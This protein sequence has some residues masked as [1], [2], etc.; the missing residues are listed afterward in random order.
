M[1]MDEDQDKKASNKGALNFISTVDN[2]RYVHS[3]VPVFGR[4]CCHG[5]NHRGRQRGLAR[6]VR[7][8]S[9]AGVRSGESGDY[10]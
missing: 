1:K 7:M 4:R 3:R 10:P 6:I 8:S 5:N 9:Q 2:G